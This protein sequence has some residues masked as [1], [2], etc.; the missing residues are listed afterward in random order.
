MKILK[1]LTALFFLNLF[2]LTAKA[3]EKPAIR[4]ANV[5]IDIEYG[6]LLG[7]FFNL[8]LFFTKHFQRNFSFTES[9]IKHFIEKSFTLSG[10]R[11]Q[12][13]G[14]MFRELDEHFK[15]EF[16]LGVKIK[17]FDV[18]FNL[19]MGDM[20]S[21]DTRM[22]TEWSIFHIES[23]QVILN[24]NLTSSNNIEIYTNRTRLNL[25]NEDFTPVTYH[26]FKHNVKQLIED[27]EFKAAIR[28]V[29]A[30]KEI[31]PASF[32]KITLN[33]VPSPGTERAKVLKRAQDASVTIVTATGHG[34]GFFID[35]HG[36]ILT[37]YHV[38]QQS[39][40]VEVAL[41][42][43]TLIKAKVVRTNPDYD[44]ALIQIENVSSTPIGFN[45][46]KPSPGDEVFAVGSPAHKDLGRSV[47]R[48]IVSA[49]RVVEE[50]QYIQTDAGVSPGNSGGP[51]INHRGEVV[52]I[53]N[54]K[55]MSFGTE[56]VG[57]AIPVSVAMEKLNLGVE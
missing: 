47:T 14:S 33:K 29:P 57:F 13:W 2:L 44:L 5:V 53:V 22:E 42:E 56:G 19:R 25:V 7:D 32:D 55:A 18:N 39:N 17:E 23:E 36:L 34:S 15:S 49:E 21:I 24:K 9:E 43:G 26:A 40:S 46:S 51:L 41:N 28:D 6:E 35:H 20:R 45:S 54:A 4:I 30:K 38:V 48:G 12:G 27:P 10:Y 1:T 52:G 16:A 11:V 37:C 50:R 8:E 3:E 31:D